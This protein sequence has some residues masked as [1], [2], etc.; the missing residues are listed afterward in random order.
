[1][2]SGIPAITAEAAWP[3]E[4]QGQNF[5]KEIRSK[6][7]TR[8]NT[9]DEKIDSLLN[10]KSCRVLWPFWKS[11]LEAMKGITEFHY[12]MLHSDYPF[13][14]YV[15][16]YP[17]SP[18]SFPSPCPYTTLLICSMCIFLFVSVPAKCTLVFC[19]HVL[20]FCVKGILCVSHSVS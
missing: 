7:V 17:Q 19:V 2:V 6:K 9:K 11:A 3:F 12:S 20:L 18:L 15:S 5:P 1:M 16:F 4:T 8:G 10:K 13:N 14:F